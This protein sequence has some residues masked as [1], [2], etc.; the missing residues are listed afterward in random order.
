L[1]AL[2]AA[3]WISPS[4]ASGAAVLA[5]LFALLLLLLLKKKKTE[6]QT[7]PEDDGLDSDDPFATM[8][9]DTLTNGGEEYISEYGLSDVERW[10]DT[11]PAADTWGTLNDDNE[12]ELIFVSEYGLS[13]YGQLE[14]RGDLGNGSP[15]RPPDDVE[16][17]VEYAAEYGLS[18]QGA[19]KDDQ[20]D[21]LPAANPE[22]DDM[23]QYWTE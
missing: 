22:A 13:D 12:D 23:E 19:S 15:A 4:L 5:V 7:V 18:D 9:D 10:S 14:A 11:D 1:A 6:K 16:G 8:E 17:E 3:A 2:A 20:R 21:D